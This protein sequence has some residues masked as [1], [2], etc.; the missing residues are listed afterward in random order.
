MTTEI[1]STPCNNLLLFQFVDMFLNGGGGNS[2][3]LRKFYSCDGWICYN[4]FQNGFRAV[5]DGCLTTFKFMIF[6][7]A[8]ARFPVCI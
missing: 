7:L 2:G 5:I 4:G 6:L 8:I 1:T 3:N